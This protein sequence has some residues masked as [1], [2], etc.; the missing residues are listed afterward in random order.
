MSSLQDLICLFTYEEIYKHGSVLFYM[1]IVRF[2]IQL[3]T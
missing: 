3:K 2:K 1:N